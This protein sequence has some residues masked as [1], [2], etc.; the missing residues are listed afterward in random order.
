MI[1][2]Y[3]LAVLAYLV[4]GALTLFGITTLINDYIEK[5]A[6]F[7]IFFVWPAVLLILVVLI[8]LYVASLIVDNI[9]SFSMRRKDE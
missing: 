7:F 8:I 4:V 9:M 2:Y 5:W 3:L 6:A 1:I